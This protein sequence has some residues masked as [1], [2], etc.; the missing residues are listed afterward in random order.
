MTMDNRSTR[1]IVPDIDRTRFQ[2]RLFGE[3]F[4]VSPSEVRGLLR[5]KLRPMVNYSRPPEIESTD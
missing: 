1:K 2:R 5:H 3:V 4:G